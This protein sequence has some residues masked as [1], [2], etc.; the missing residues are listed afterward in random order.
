[1]QLTTGSLGHREPFDIQK[2]RAHNLITS[3]W[4]QGAPAPM[5]IDAGPIGHAQQKGVCGGLAGPG[6]VPLPK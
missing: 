2:C 6:L 3:P 1:M 5:L 4:V